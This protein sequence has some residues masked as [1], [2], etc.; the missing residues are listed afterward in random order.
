MMQARQPMP[1]T[2][3]RRC[4]S[5]RAE[6]ALDTL[7]C[8]DD[9]GRTWLG[10]RNSAASASFNDREIRLLEQVLATVRRG[11]D[12]RQ[13]ARSPELAGLARKVAVMKA[14]SERRKRE[15]AK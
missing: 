9:S 3:C 12:A 8:P 1:T 7:A 2:R 10:H 11:G 4:N 15:L 5:P 13:L 14:S 6:H